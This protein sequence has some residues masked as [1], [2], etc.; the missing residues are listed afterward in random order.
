M[1]EEKPVKGIISFWIPT[2]GTIILIIASMIYFLNI[3]IS[4]TFLTEGTPRNGSIT[5]ILQRS[6]ID[7]ACGC[8]IWCTTDIWLDNGSRY[9]FGEPCHIVDHLERNQTYTFYFEA[10]KNTSENMDIHY[11][12]IRICKIADSHGT[13]FW[14]YNG[15]E[16]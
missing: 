10:F 16:G 12:D 7:D 6:H 4:N 3:N 8:P 2:I 1:K 13:V 14:V 11:W 5:G 9:Q 15:F